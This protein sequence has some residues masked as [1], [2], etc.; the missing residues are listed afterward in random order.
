VIEIRGTGGQNGLNARSRRFGIN[1][2]GSFATLDASP[3]LLFCRDQ[4]GQIERMGI[5]I[6]TH[7]PPP[8]MID[9]TEVLR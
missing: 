6:S 4:D 8:V 9:S 1:E 7:L 2:V 5:V 3:E